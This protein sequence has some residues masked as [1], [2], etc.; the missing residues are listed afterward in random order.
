MGKKG[1]MKL[2]FGM[3]FSII[4]IIL[5]LSVAFYAIKKI[6]SFQQNTQVGLFIDGLQAD[7]DS[8]W[9]SDY[10][11]EEKSYTIS[12]KVD[13]VCFEEGT[14]NIFFKP[15]GSGGEFD[16]TTIKHVNLFNDFCIDNRDGKISL[17]ME[18][19]FGEAL[20]TITEE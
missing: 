11:S 12:N 10:G 2:S 15:A 9:A 13:S 14:R 3:I 18:K 20:V 16:Y 17:R 5:F 7:V 6:I 8:L 19:K 4:L 1:Q